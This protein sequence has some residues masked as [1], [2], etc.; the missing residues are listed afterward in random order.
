MVKH[1]S[2]EWAVVG[3]DVL[4]GSGVFNSATFASLLR[5]L[6]TAI[7]ASEQWFCVRCCG[8][9]GARCCVIGGLIV[10]LDCSVWL[11]DIPVS[12]PGVVASCFIHV[13]PLLHVMTRASSL[14]FPRN[15]VSPHMP[16]QHLQ[17]G[18]HV[19]DLK[20]WHV[21]LLMLPIVL[22]LVLQSPLKIGGLRAMVSGSLNTVVLTV[23]SLRRMVVCILSTQCVLEE[24]GTSSGSLYT[25][26]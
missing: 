21:R 12:L 5:F 19:K 14:R 13:L 17:S 22:S 4:F 26:Q 11:S 18:L 8:P 23:V 15:D 25:D 7:V 24:E 20:M 10:C 9:L 16:T 2:A 1:G 6:G 3:G